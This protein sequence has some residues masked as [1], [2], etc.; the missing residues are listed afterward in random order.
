MIDGIVFVVMGV[1]F[2][3]IGLG[4]ALVSKNPKAAAAWLEKWG[5][6]FRIGGPI[7]AL[8]GLVRI[9]ADIARRWP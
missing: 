1:W 5:I 9:V 4:K 6:V 2:L 8:A 3:L 7:M